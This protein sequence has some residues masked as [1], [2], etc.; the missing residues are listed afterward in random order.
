MAGTLKCILLSASYSGDIDAHTSYRDLSAHEVHVAD[1]GRI[2]G[3]NAGGHA[4]S[5]SVVCSADNGNNW[6]YFDAGD[7]S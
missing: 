2:V 4:I 5:A 3:Y 7:V 1:P 6:A